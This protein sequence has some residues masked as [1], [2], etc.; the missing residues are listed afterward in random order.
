M[1]RLGLANYDDSNSLTSQVKVPADIAEQPNI[2]HLGD[3]FLPAE[4]ESLCLA[5]QTTDTPCTSSEM[6]GV[7][8]DRLRVERSLEAAHC[9]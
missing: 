2:D 4:D 1:R 6:Q 5:S 9:V 7:C 8:W 3:G